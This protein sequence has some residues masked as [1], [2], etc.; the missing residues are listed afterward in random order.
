MKGKLVGG[1]G[2]DQAANLE[3]HD[4]RNDNCVD[5]VRLAVLHKL[6]VQLGLEEHLRRDETGAGVDFGLEILQLNLVLLH[7]NVKQPRQ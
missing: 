7:A 2:T 1:D 3:Q 6:L 5:T 4:S